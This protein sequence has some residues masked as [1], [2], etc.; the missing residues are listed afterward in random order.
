MHIPD[1][2]LDAKTAIATGAMALAG[3]GVAL[4]QARLSLPPRRVPLLGLSAAFVFAAQMLNFPVAGGTSGHLIG[5][6]L[7]AALLGPSAAVIVLSAVL[8]VQC[9]M[10]A[11]GGITALGANVF[12]MAV[13]GGVAG[14]AVY[15]AVSRL[16]SGLF[17][18]VLAATFAAWCSTVLAA[19]ACAGELAVSHTVAWR[20]AFPAMAGVHVLI[21]VGEGVITALVLAAIGKARPDLLGLTEFPKPR[22]FQVIAPTPAA[23]GNVGPTPSSAIP[24]ATR[25]AGDVVA[26]TPAA[27]GKVGPTP[28]SAFPA[29]TQAA[30]DGVGPTFTPAP[31]TATALASAA[32]APTGRSSAQADAGVGPTAT[33]ARPVHR[34]GVVSLVA[35]GLLISLGLALF[36][37][38]FACSWPD[39]L[40]KTARA[41]GFEQHATQPLLPAPAPDYKAP[42]IGSGTMAIS[43][44]G[45]AGTLL[46]FGLAWA[47]ARILVPA[48]KACEGSAV[49]VQGSANAGDT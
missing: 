16:A 33:P 17:G 45:A 34:E 44:A 46:V 29:D 6:V 35:F 31:A 39:G 5:A 11:D 38:P 25:A 8:I 42:W 23:L 21:G 27:L 14:W 12:N 32:G 40:D 3:L 49:G 41:L 13:I 20:A 30:D 10:F 22:G 24:G 47:L 18:R 26:P 15:F 37:A 7:T 28:S 43:V 9:F 1:G 2:F 48:R 36:V 4:R 19:I